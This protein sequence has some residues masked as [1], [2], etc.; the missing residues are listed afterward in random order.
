MIKRILT[1]SVLCAVWLGSGCTS[2]DRDYMRNH[3][4]QLD[5]RP[6]HRNHPADI[7]LAPISS[8]EGR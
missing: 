6:P 1:A 4:V 2:S 3:I 7:P 8:S 5:S